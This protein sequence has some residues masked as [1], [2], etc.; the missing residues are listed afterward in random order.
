MRTEIRKR[1][2]VSYM[3]SGL[4]SFIIVNNTN[5]ISYVFNIIVIVIVNE[6]IKSL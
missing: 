6:K 4:G 1:N 2:E 5:T 3:P